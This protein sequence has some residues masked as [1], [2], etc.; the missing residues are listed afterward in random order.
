M[1]II[2]T[3]RLK[4]NLNFV[5]EY[6]EDGQQCALII[7]AENVVKNYQAVEHSVQA[8]GLRWCAKCNLWQFKNAAG[9]CSAC[10]PPRA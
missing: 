8:T 2:K 3:K 6:E 10:N 9:D 1:K 7:S 4:D 5:V